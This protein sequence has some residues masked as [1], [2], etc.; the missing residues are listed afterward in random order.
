MLSPLKRNLS[1]RVSRDSHTVNR[2][3]NMGIEKQ[4]ESEKS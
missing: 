1:L 4:E 2:E 3:E